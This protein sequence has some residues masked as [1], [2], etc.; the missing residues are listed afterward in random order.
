MSY[1]AVWSENECSEQERCDTACFLYHQEVHP[2]P[3]A[4][5]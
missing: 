5:L 4:K 3:G 1:L 2:V